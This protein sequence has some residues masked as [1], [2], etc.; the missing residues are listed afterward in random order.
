VLT[1]RRAA[2]VVAVAVAVLTAVGLAAVGPAALAS[3][4]PSGSASQLVADLRHAWQISKGRGVTV[5]VLSTGVDPNATGL[6]GRV[7]VGPDY[8]RLP[9]PLLLEGTLIA[10]GIAGDRDPEGTLGIAPQARIISVRVDSDINEPGGQAFEDGAPVSGIVAS[11]IRYAVSHGARVIYIDWLPY[12]VDSKD[13]DSAMHYALSKGVV[14]TTLARPAGSS[15]TAFWYPAAFPGVIA[16]AMVTLPP[17]YQPPYGPFPSTAHNDSVL[18]AVPDNATTEIGPQDQ[19]YDAQAMDVAPAWI[20]GTA[21]LIKSAYPGLSPALVARAIAL[22]ARDHPAGG[23]NVKIG[24]GLI[25]PYGALIEAGRLAKQPGSVTAGLDPAA[26]FGPAPGVIDA[27]HRSAARVAVFAC[28]AALGVILLVAAVILALR[29]PRIARLPELAR[30]QEFTQR[31]QV[32]HAGLD[33]DPAGQPHPRD[34][35]GG[36]GQRDH[37]VAARRQPDVGGRVVRLGLG[38]RLGAVVGEPGHERHAE[39]GHLAAHRPLTEVAGP[40]SRAHLGQ[41]ACESLQRL[42]ALLD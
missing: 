14:I 33:L 18:V 2:M 11:A 16:A 35:G 34:V 10:N 37:V 25:D 36:S 24:F 42:A 20:A 38:H 31:Q 6:A 5:A 19:L 4:M 41:P 21:A 7:T 23:Y 13:V 28:V 12:S 40:V 27:V 8:V 39:I 15:I 26:H 29:R 1:P 30:L 17:P 9:H 22:S 3:S 32:A